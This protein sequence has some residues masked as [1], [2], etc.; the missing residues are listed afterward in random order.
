MGSVESTEP[1]GDDLE[2]VLTQSTQLNSIQEAPHRGPNNELR[3]E[4]DEK[5]I[6]VQNRFFLHLH[7]GRL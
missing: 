6:V 1:N 4:F 3:E 2:W 5:D 7:I